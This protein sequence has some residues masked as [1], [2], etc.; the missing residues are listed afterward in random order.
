MD[1]FDI[2]I[3]LA[4]VETKSI[5]GASEKLFLSQST[6]SYR[7]TKLEERLQTKLINRQ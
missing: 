7:I 3:F 6:V 5:T 4:I 1:L 2:E